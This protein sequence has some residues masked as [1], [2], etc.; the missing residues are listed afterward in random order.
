MTV[1]SS[2]VYGGSCA[3]GAGRLTTWQVGL[4][5]AAHYAL[6]AGPVS[7]RETRDSCPP[8]VRVFRILPLPLPLACSD[9]R[10]IP[11]PFLQRVERV[12]THNANHCS[13]VPT[14]DRSLHL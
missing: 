9:L 1:P 2:A 4:A 5:G 7:Q 6:N 12:E 3:R 14:I 10:K 8:R 13:A 11:L